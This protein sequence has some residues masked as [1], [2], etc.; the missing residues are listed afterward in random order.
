[1]FLS[2][3]LFNHVANDR[4]SLGAKPCLA[5][6]RLWQMASTLPKQN[7]SIYFVGLVNKV[8]IFFYYSYIQVNTWKVAWNYTLGLLGGI[9]VHPNTIH[10][11]LGIIY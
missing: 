5:P 8:V 6:E 1:M 3:T 9:I 7:M 10:M 4:G 2:I 11:H